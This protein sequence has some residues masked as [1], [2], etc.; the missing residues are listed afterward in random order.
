MV[1]AA[2]WTNLR[3]VVHSYSDAPLAVDQIRCY[4]NNPPEKES[5]TAAT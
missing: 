2:V 5:L 4:S 3:Q 1:R